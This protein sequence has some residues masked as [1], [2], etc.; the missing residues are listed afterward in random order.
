[1]SINGTDL[2]TWCSSATLEFEVDEQDATTF[3]SGGYSEVLGGLKSGTLSLTFKQ[4][5][6]AGA[7]D[8]T[9]WPIL[10]EVVPFTLKAK[11]A[12][13]SATNPLYGGNVLI[14]GYTPV[15]GEVGNIAEFEVEFPT[16]G[17]LTRATA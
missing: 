4:D 11:S 15:G 12:A 16:S 8:A 2:S 14:A 17:A 9:L 3:T 6:A 13:T 7:V 5:Y 10:G 1:M